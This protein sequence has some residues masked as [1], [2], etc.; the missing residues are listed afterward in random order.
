MKNIEVLQMYSNIKDN[1]EI[2][3]LK[4]IKLS[5][6]LLDNIDILENF[7]KKIQTSMQEDDA[8]KE[9]ESKRIEICEKYADK[10][11]NNNTIMKEINGIKE[12]SLDTTNKKF[13]TEINTLKK[14]FNTVIDERNKQIVEYNNFLQEDTELIFKKIPINLLP[15]D[16]SFNIVTILKPLLET[17]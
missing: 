14:T 11:E 7:V 5:L 12:Y 2:K 10:D 9:Y 4:G 13:N 3:N 6:L 15:E 1:V 17:E 16:I 8:Y